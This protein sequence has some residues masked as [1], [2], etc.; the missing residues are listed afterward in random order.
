MKLLALALHPAAQVG[1][2]AAAAS[3]LINALRARRVLAAT[4]L[5]GS[6]PASSAVDTTLARGLAMRMPFGKH[7]HKPL[8]D[9]PIPYLR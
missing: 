7:K 2:I 6:T 4:V 5:H 9:V 1:E 3:K 8:R